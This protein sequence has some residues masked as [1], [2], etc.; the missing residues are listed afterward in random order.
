MPFVLKKGGGDEEKDPSGR[1][2]DMERKHCPTCKRELPPWYEECPDDGAR[3]VNLADLT[4]DTGPPIPTHLLDAVDDT[5]SD[6][7]APN[8]AD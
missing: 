6:A 7:P 3:T 8:D 5:A 4:P 1:A 2:V